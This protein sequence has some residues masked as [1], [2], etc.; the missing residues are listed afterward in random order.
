MVG[1][2]THDSTTGEHGIGRKEKPS[3]EIIIVYQSVTSQ[4]DL[5]NIQNIRL[6]LAGTARCGMFLQIFT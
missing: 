1:D 5:V 3:E 4:T 6:F 2:A